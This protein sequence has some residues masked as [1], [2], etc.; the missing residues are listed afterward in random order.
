M[1]P[2]EAFAH[3]RRDDLIAYVLRAEDI[4]L[5]ASMLVMSSAMDGKALERDDVADY[6]RLLLEAA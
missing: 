5:A 4:D 1:T 6:L 3:L 2:A